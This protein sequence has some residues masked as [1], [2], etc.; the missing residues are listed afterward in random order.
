MIQ[1][2][3][4]PLQTSSLYAFADSYVMARESCEWYG[5]KYVA[6]N[7][8]NLYI[9]RREKFFPWDWLRT[10]ESKRNNPTYRKTYFVKVG[11]LYTLL[12]HCRRT[13]HS[14]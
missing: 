2:I 12:I 7:K 11:S 14:H 3:Y 1:I 9:L 13:R 5:S 8:K 10:I 6:N 4:V